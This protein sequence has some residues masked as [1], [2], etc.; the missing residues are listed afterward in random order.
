MCEE[1]KRNKI[2]IDYMFEDEVTP[3]MIEAGREVISSNWLEFISD[4]GSETLPKYIKEMYLAMREG[5][6]LFH[7]E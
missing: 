2:R 1:C 4:N 5:D 3:E 7:R 6:P